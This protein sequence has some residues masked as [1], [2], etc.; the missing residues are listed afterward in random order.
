MSPM[1]GLSVGSTAI[2]AVLV[3]RRTG[4]VQ[5]AGTAPY[6]GVADLGEVVARLAA[7]AGAPVRQAR[8]A[9]ERDVLQLRTVSPAPPLRAPAARAYVAL[10]APRLF[11]R[12]GWPLVTDAV[13]VPLG[14]DMR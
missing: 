7:E 5:W 11:R 12:N 3:E 8:V 14:K 13:L 1:L 6:A 10:E 9:L 4:A 2:R